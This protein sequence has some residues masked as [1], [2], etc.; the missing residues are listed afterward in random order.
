M[1]LS[2]DYSAQAIKECIDQKFTKCMSV[3]YITSYEIERTQFNEVLP[4]KNSLKYNLVFY[5]ILICNVSYN[6]M[7]DF[8]IYHKFR[9]RMQ[10]NSLMKC[11]VGD[12]IKKMHFLVSTKYLSLT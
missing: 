11:Y 12:F 2:G 8:P 5:Q 9:G 3:H 7:N 1:C 6:Q 4:N 10:V